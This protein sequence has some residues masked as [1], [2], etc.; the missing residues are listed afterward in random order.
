MGPTASPEEPRDSLTYD[1]LYKQFLEE[2]FERRSLNNQG[3]QGI[4]ESVKRRFWEEPP[5]LCSQA[6]GK[7]LENRLREKGW[8]QQDLASRLGLDP[9]AVTHWIAGG[10]I[11]LPYLA[12]VLLEF[13]SPWS[14]LPIPARQE[15]AL[16]AYLVALSLARERL[17][18][19]GGPYALD[20]ERFWCLF[21]LLSEP[22]WERA[23]RRNDDD[24]LR[25]EAN[26]ILEAARS[27]L[28]TGTGD[29]ANLAKLQQIA[30]VDGL[31]RV[32]R[33]WGNAWLVCVDSILNRWAVR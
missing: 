14:A 23:V 4:E 32:V 13:K 30:S 33:E 31:R 10:N 26:R 2:F 16:Q 21:H 25:K 11:A 8:Q 20:R 18:P 17:E 7:W 22:Y 1:R 5:R 27:S 19:A 9:S 12:K 24:L 28:G 15:L 29:V 6:I 3:N